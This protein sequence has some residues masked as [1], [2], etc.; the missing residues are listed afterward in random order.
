MGRD[1]LNHT[2][3]IIRGTGST[4]SPLRARRVLSLRTTKAS[5]RP[6]L[7][8]T[9]RQTRARSTRK[10]TRLLMSTAMAVDTLRLLR[11]VV[12]PQVPPLPL[13]QMLPDSTLRP[14]RLHRSPLLLEFK[15]RSRLPSSSSLRRLLSSS[16]RALMPTHTV[17]T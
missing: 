16:P 15:P 12:R 9:Y 5:T 11:P 6:L 17:G 3:N 2:N 13:P 4:S 8:T 14:R 1:S 10:G 7:C